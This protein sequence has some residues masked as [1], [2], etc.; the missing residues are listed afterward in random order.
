MD[1]ENYC[2]M[3]NG[4]TEEVLIGIK[5]SAQKIADIVSK[6][7]GPYGGNVMLIN[8]RT[9]RITKDGISVLRSM[10]EPKTESDFIALSVI[11]SASDETNRKAGDGTTATYK[12][13]VS[14][15]VPKSG[16]DSLTQ[17]YV[18]AGKGGSGTG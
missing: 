11:R 3:I 14:F 17:R 13:S 5:K 12:E 15:G 18:E 7:A 2:T 10:I 1:N 4:N 8:G 6:T 16:F 9:A